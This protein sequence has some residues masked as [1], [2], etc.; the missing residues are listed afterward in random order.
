M[1][2]SALIA[3]LAIKLAEVDAAG[4]ATCD[5]VAFPIIKKTPH[6][7]TLSPTFAPT[8]APTKAPTSQPV[9]L[10]TAAGKP[11]T[12]RP[13]LPPV[14]PDC[15]C[16]YK[17]D[18]V[19]GQG[20][21]TGGGWIL[22]KSG[23]GNTGTYLNTNYCQSGTT[24]YCNGYAGT[25][26]NGIKANYGFNA[27]Y[28]KGVPEGSTNFDFDGN[29]FHFHSETHSTPL[30]FLEVIDGIHA[31]WMGTGWLSTKIQPRKNDWRN[32][33]C[34]MVAVQDH[35]EP[36][37]HDTW[38]I[39]IW[40]CGTSYERLVFNSTDCGLMDNEYFFSSTPLATNK[41]LQ[42]GADP[43]RL[44]FDTNVNLPLPTEGFP[45]LSL[46][47]DP[48]PL[49]F[50]GTEVG[51]AD[52]AIGGQKG[53]GNIQIHKSKAPNKALEYMLANGGVCNCSTVP[54]AGDGC[55]GFITGGGWINLT[56]RAYLRRSSCACTAEDGI[57]ADDGPSNC[58][59]V[60][61]ATKPKANF[62]FNAKQFFGVPTGSTNFD[63]D[64]HGFH[65]HTHNS[66]AEYDGLQVLC[67]NTTFGYGAGVMARWTGIGRIQWTLANASP[68]AGSWD[69]G[70]RFFVSAQ[71]WG[72]PG[73]MDTFR[74]RIMDK[75]GKSVLFDT[76]YS[77]GFI[78]DI[79]P[80]CGKV[81]G[82]DCDD[83]P[84]FSGNSLGGE[85]EA[86]GGGNIQVHCKGGPPDAGADCSK[87][88]FPKAAQSPDWFLIDVDDFNTGATTQWVTAASGG[89]V[90]S[91]DF[92]GSY[93]IKA[94]GNK[95]YIQ[96]TLTTAQLKNATTVKVSYGFCSVGNLGTTK[97]SFLVGYKVDTGG[98][99]PAADYS[100]F[101]QYIFDNVTRTYNGCVSN[102]EGMFS[103]PSIGVRSL[104][105]QFQG[106]MSAADDSIY[107]DY[108]KVEGSKV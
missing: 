65:F 108:V 51:V 58:N 87:A 44:V 15:S 96:K 101:N 43:A 38:R 86:K 27:M 40:Y 37:Y 85:G 47:L 5:D 12:L 6:P 10:T 24:S 81:G 67:S 105:L 91:P 39:R 20:K 90:R 19:E 1:F 4:A 100:W 93:M 92:G 63:L 80:F 52:P 55:N 77:A 50:N 89:A 53:G 54:Y 68:N 84:D 107:I 35:G 30:R 17:G 28:R 104:M 64:G 33:F 82:Y 42:C 78:F 57:C 83:D 14:P 48:D 36:G 95:A 74:L 79:D 7:T 88:S 103:I 8:K 32:N 45:P 99:G 3:L 60:D 2:K 21:V 102:S 69:Y 66:G 41:F 49:R 97:E 25:G 11:S 13:T 26:M 56:D 76:D 98:G 73:F 46:A 71:D 75:D 106:N 62:G 23:T 59:A 72:E 31:R 29:G 9:P 70:Y 18:A 34:F 16:G 94:N 22:L 61:M